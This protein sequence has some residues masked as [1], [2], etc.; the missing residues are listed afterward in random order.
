MPFRKGDPNHPSKAWSER[1]SQRKL[2]MAEA[3][4]KRY[5]KCREREVE[6]GVIPS[7]TGDFRAPSEVEF[8]PPRRGFGSVHVEQLLTRALTPGKSQWMLAVEHGC[9]QATV[10]RSLRGVDQKTGR[11]VGRPM[12]TTREERDKVRDLKDADPFG[13]HKD[14]AAAA[15]VLGLHLNEKQIASVLAY[16]KDPNSGSYGRRAS[17]RYAYFDEK[18]ADMHIGSRWLP[19]SNPCRRPHPGTRRRARCAR[20]AHRNAPSTPAA[21]RRRRF[22]S[23]F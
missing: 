16:K 14:I 1:L 13:R 18:V 17:N 20:A 22:R 6:L 23:A 7:E 19:N 9:S 10:S 15:A 11:P 2:S 21:T 4:A 5:K 3:S 12:K 8:A